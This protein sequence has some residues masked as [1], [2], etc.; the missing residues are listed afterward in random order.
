M[1]WGL[2]TTGFAHYGD[3][4][5]IFFQEF[6]SYIGKFELYLGEK[7]VRNMNFSVPGIN[8]KK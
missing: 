4:D 6:S 3:M 2:L 5:K 1:D 7:D 8:V